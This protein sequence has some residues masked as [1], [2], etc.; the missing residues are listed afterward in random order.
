MCDRPFDHAP[1]FTDPA[2]SS[3]IIAA[4]RVLR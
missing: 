1:L 4:P 3:E 2:S